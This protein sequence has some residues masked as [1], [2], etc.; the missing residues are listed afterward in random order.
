MAAQRRGRGCPGGVPVQRAARGALSDPALCPA[1]GAL[2]MAGRACVRQRRG[3]CCARQ[4]VQA[5]KLV[6]C[7]GHRGRRALIIGDLLSKR[8]TM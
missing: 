8:G 2:G 3:S 1:L 7:V 5:V 6:W 4:L